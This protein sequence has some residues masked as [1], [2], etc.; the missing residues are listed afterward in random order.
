MGITIHYQG[1]INDISLIDK[2]TQELND[3]SD[4]INWNYHIIDDDKL[5]LKGIYMEPPPNCEALSFLFDKS[6]GILKDRIILFHDDMG[7]NHYKYNHTKTQ[8]API[9]VHITIIKLLKYLKSKYINDLKVF[10]EGEYWDTE[11]PILLRKK[12]DFLA[13][14]IDKLAGELEKIERDP[15]DSD[16]TLLSKIEEVIRKLQENNNTDNEN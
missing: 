4:E 8:Y 11:D 3:I 5:N 6:S 12:F 14:M 15:G 2:C 9:E 10:D 16:L 7:E 13:K 1:K